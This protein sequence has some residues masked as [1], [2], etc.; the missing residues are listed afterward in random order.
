MVESC[1]RALSADELTYEENQAGRTAAATAHPSVHFA[2]CLRAQ[3]DSDYS[4]AVVASNFS[5]LPFLLWKHQLRVRLLHNSYASLPYSRFNE[6]IPFSTN[7]CSTYFH[8][9]SGLFPCTFTR[10]R[11][12]CATICTM[13]YLSRASNSV[14]PACPVPQ[15]IIADLH[16]AL[17]SRTARHVLHLP[18]NCSPHRRELHQTHR[19]VLADRCSHQA[20][21][22]PQARTSRARRERQ[23][24]ARLCRRLLHLRVTCTQV[25]VRSLTAATKASIIGKKLRSTAQFDDRSSVKT[26]SAFIPLVCTARG[27]AA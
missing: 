7:L 24:C 26:R 20:R 14:R 11:K 1:F 17:H 25:S 13:N 27:G 12:M 10:M 18:N 21:R 16:R 6:S 22:A 5:F 4:W 2:A 23:P 3:L 19:G 9:Q 15:L 8:H